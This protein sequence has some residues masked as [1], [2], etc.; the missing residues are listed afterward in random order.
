MIRLEIEEYKRRRA[1]DIPANRGVDRQALVKKLQ[2][3]FKAQGGSLPKGA[4]LPVLKELDIDENEIKEK[5]KQRIEKKYKNYS[6]PVV[7]NYL[8]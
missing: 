4:E 3:K 6:N 2:Q 7:K 5:A 1:L 8:L